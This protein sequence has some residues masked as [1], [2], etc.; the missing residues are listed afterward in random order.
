MMK[1]NLFILFLLLALLPLGEANAFFPLPPFKIDAGKS[2]KKTLT[3]V[4]TRVGE[5][6]KKIQEST[7]VQQ[8]ITYGKGAKEALEYSK[9]VMGAVKDKDFG[10]MGQLLGEMN[11]VQKQKKEARE[12]AALDIDAKNKATEKKI[13]ELRENNDVLRRE[14]IDKPSK[15]RQN[16]RKIRKNEKQIEKLTSDARATADKINADLLSQISSFDLNLNDLRGKV[17]DLI[18]SFQTI[19]ADYD[20]TAELRETAESLMPADDVELSARV[21]DAYRKTYLANYYTVLSKVIARTSL[22]KSQME[23][24]NEKAKKNNEALV[25]VEGQTPAIT[26]LAKM[27]TQNAQALINYTE[28]LLL[29]LELDMAYDLAHSKFV[30]ISPSKTVEDFNFDNYR[31]DTADNS[32]L[33]KDGLKDKIKD[34]VKSKV[35][36]FGY[37]NVKKTFTADDNDP[38][39]QVVIETMQDVKKT[40]KEFKENG[41]R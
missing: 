38:T 13:S 32:L 28:L 18:G 5:V 29:R 12:K 41:A 20:A 23:D 21:L 8:A 3:T 36:E 31:L 34:K 35:Q 33:S 30:R 24:D 2:I 39:S 15:K 17:T 10:K 9:K 4:Q 26:A 1:K 27:K 7:L 14:I 22:L 25:V 40:A 11:A 16:E 19:G 6:S 37:G